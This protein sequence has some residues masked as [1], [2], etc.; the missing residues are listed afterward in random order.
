MPPLSDEDQQ[1]SYRETVD[2]VWRNLSSASFP[3]AADGR[4]KEL[5]KWARK[6]RGEFLSKYVPMLMKNEKVEEERDEGGEASMDLINEWLK[7]YK[8]KPHCGTCKCK[9]PREGW[10]KDVNPR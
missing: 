7:Q 9:L 10:Q 3:P 8:N 4:A 6:N 5:W 1:R 2:L